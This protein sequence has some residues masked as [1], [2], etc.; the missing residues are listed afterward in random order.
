[1]SVTIADIRFT[2][3]DYCSPLGF[4]APSCSVHFPQPRAFL[5]ALDDLAD[6]LDHV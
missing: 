4:P 2:F 6:Q 1:M 3:H 5:V